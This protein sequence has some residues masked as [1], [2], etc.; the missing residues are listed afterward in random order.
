MLAAFTSFLPVMCWV[1]PEQAGV[2]FH[3][4]EPSGS[5]AAL[6]SGLPGTLPVEGCGALGSRAAGTRPLPLQQTAGR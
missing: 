5:G 6:S 1:G 2:Y 3:V 4:M